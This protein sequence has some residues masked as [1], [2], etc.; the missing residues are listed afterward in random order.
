[1]IP[2]DCALAVQDG[3]VCVVG[4]AGDVRDGRD[5]TGVYGNDTQYLR[6][7]AVRVTDPE[8]PD[9]G[10][11]RLERQAGPDGVETVLIGGAPGEGRGDARRFVLNRS[12]TVDGDVVSLETTLTNYTAAERTVEVDL[13]AESAFRHVF[14]CPGFFSPRDP[15]ERDLDETERESGAGLSGTS[16]DG[17]TRTAT[18][19]LD[20]ADAETTDADDAVRA[21]ASRTLSIPA[22]ESETIVAT[23]RLQPTRGRVDVDVDPTVSMDDYPNLFDAAAETLRALMLPEGVPAAGAPR[24]VAPFGRDA[25]LVGFQTLPFAPELTRSVLTYFAGRQATSTDPDTLAEP[26]KIPH[27]G[28]RGDLPALGESIRSPYYGTV[29][30]TPLFAAL[31]AAYGEWAGEASIPDELYDAAVDAAE[32]TLSTGDEDGFLWYEPHDH[33]HGL[34]HQG[35]KDSADAIARPDGDAATPPV[36]L[37]E[38]QAYAYRALDGVADLA[39]ARGDDDLAERLAE[40][41]GEIQTAF[42]ESFWLPE[43]GCYALALD[44]DGAVDAVAS[45]QGHALW[46]G[47]VPEERADSVIDRLLRSDVLTDAGLRTYAASHD[48]F[49]P[50]SYHRG[51]VWPHDTSLAAMGCA[52]YGREDAVEALAERGLMTLSTAATGDPGRWGFPEL[53]IGLDGTEAD[54]GRA[55]HPDSCEPAAWSAGSAFGFARAALGVGVEADS[56]T[57]DPADGIDGTIEA[58][59]FCRDRRHAVRTSGAATVVTPT[60]EAPASTGADPDRE[61]DNQEVTS[62]G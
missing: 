57:V 48:A 4:E 50:L 11:D 19:Q 49:D 16:P 53:L 38:V 12:L 46:C 24:F 42:D 15:V 52:R 55:P 10:W 7:F 37:A 8:A 3:V 35:W 41:A 47:I 5:E 59:L 36:A 31:V 28:R 26:G 34:T 54:A 58:T 39:S 9:S 18:V 6:E 45:N 23:V 32:W 33:E 21:T 17:T 14:E 29:D 13:T 60:S 2:E 20:G 51:S 61:H 44:A 43:E 62:D 25:L 27:E 40:R 30:A 22:G 1:M 56:P